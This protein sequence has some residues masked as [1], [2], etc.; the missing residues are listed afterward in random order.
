MKIADRNCSMSRF[1]CEVCENE[2][3]EVS[4]LREHMMNRHDYRAEFKCENFKK[5]FRR[6]HGLK[7]HDRE[8]SND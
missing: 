1:Y 6:S 4:S 8:L 3:L 5:T 2:F 7:E